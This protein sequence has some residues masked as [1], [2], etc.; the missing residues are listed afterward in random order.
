MENI[1]QS[2]GMPMG[3]D[4]DFGTNADGSK[5]QE[6]CQFCYQNGKFTDEGITL[7]QKIA[8]NIA[9]A[10]KMGMPADEAKKMAKEVLPKLKRWRGGK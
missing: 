1:C 3:K 9:I 10:A 2:C 8:K 7:E 6:Y 5:N 4:S